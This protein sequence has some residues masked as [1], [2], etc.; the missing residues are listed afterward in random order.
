MEYFRR[1]GRFWFPNAMAVVWLLFALPALY[2]F[3]TTIHEGSHAFA[4][5]VSSGNFPKLAPFPHL[6]ADGNFLNGVAIPDRGSTE[7]VLERASCESR[8]KTRNP[9]LAGFIG[10]PQFIALG[11][12]ILFSVVF[13]LTTVEDPLVR[14]GLRAWYFAACVDFM[15]NTARG[16]VGGCNASADWSKFMLR[17]DIDGGLFALMTWLFWLL[18]LSHFLWV[19]WSP[20]SRESTTQARFWDYRWIS[21]ILGLLSLLA[22]ILSLAVSDPGI[23][24]SSVAFILPL[25]IQFLS[26]GWYWTYFGL[27]FKYGEAR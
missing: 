7:T 1:L 9:R 17:S 21:F 25:V 18:I 27:T 13:I 8:T 15:Y 12:I 26:L 5:L 22:V 14:F 24:K 20:W 6:T 3:Q 11:L 2:F 16:L 19:Y 23:D 10:L 4:A